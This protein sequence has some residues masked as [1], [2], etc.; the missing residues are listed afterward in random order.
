M[1]T[2]TL[3]PIELV[4]YQEF[5]SRDEAIDAE[6][7]IKKWGRRKKDALVIKVGKVLLLCVKRIKLDSIDY[8]LSIRS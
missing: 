3:L 8:R 2:S 6:R 5:A 7:K 1:N 4:F